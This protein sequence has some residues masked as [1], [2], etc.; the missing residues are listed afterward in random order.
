MVRCMLVLAM[1]F[2]LSSQTDAQVILYHD[3]PSFSAALAPGAYLEDFNAFD[4]Q[5][6]VPTPQLFSGGSGPFAY[7][8]TDPF[9]TAIYYTSQATNGFV[10]G[11]TQLVGDTLT[12]TFTSG[13]VHAAGGTFFL[14]DFNGFTIAGPLTVTLNSGENSLQM[15]TADYSTEP[16]LGFTSVAPIT[17]ITITSPDQYPT[18]DNLYVGNVTG[19]PEPSSLILVTAAGFGWFWRRR[20]S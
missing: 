17:S 10:A 7:Q 16:F 3:Q 14:T 12:I 8:L 13:N 19:V 20:A 9:S 2:T 6:A 11:G 5:T 1:A 4:G 18:V 15:S